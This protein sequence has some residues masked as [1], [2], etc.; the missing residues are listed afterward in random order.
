MAKKR[1]RILI[2]DDSQMNREILSEMLSDE[3]DIIEAENGVEALELIE[4]YRA[5]LALVLLDIV[6]PELDGLGVLN[7]MQ[8]R[9]WTDRVPVMMI[10]AESGSEQVERAFALGAKDFIGRPFNAH[11]V[12]R[13]VVNAILLYARQRHLMDMV[14]E[15]IY[16]KEQQS[17]MMIDVLGHIVEFRM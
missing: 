1:Y 6:M 10:S 16:E 12:K 3:C 8:Q 17:N 15:Q 9:G 5:E 13:R 2:A 11:I 4:R 7:E 14:V